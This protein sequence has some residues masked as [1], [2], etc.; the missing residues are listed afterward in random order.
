M[1]TL[2]QEQFKSRVIAN[3]PAN[4]SNKQVLQAFRRAGHTIEGVTFSDTA[5]IQP[6]PLTPEI[7][8][9]PLAPD[10]TLQ[11]PSI[12][13]AIAP[14]IEQP[15]SPP[16]IQPQEIGEIRAPTLG[17]NI[18]GSTGIGTA[19]KTFKDSPIANLLKEEG[20]LGQFSTGFIKKGLETGKSITK[21]KRDINKAVPLTK[22]LDDFKKFI[23]GVGL[24]LQVR[25]KIMD[26]LQ[27]IPP[28]VLEREG[29][30]Q[31]VGALSNE[32]AQF[33]FGGA[34]F[35][36]LLNSGR[37]AGFLRNLASEKVT[38]SI[39]CPALLKA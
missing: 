22:R 23:P 35:G 14:Q 11:Q 12:E 19:I 8:P 33:M 6:E 18:L 2:T 10:A 24:T 29:V 38:P 37:G 9:Q 36:N 34:M 17:E 16:S 32:I 28:E 1:A 13:P 31:E 5:T 27:S 39:V 20:P 7:S 4:L 30:G 15:V 3:K 21:L 26:E 25:D